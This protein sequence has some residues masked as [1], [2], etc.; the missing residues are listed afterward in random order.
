[1]PSSDKLLLS[2]WAFVSR[3]CPHVNSLP[4]DTT[5]AFITASHVQKRTSVQST[6]CG[7]YTQ[8]RQS[9]RAGEVRPPLLLRAGWVQLGT[10]LEVVSGGWQSF[11]LSLEYHKALGKLSDFEKSSSS[12]AHVTKAQSP[13]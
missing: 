13:G 9:R 8:R 2:R 3:R 11:A 7:R 12:R 6:G 1:M 10:V 5:S 4:I